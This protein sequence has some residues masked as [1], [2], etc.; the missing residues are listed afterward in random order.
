MG[1]A[2]RAAAGEPAAELPSHEVRWVLER[3]FEGVAGFDS[4]GIC[5][6]T[7][8]ALR[9]M[10]GFEE[11]IDFRLPWHQLVHP[12]DAERV[13]EARDRLAGFGSFEC[14]LRCFRTDGAP[15]VGRF[16]VFEV[17]PQ[18]G[19]RTAYISCVE[20]VTEWK[21]IEAALNLRTAEQ[22]RSNAELE[23]FAHIAAHDLKEP[24][25]KLLAFS[26]LLEK[27]L[28]GDLP[29]AAAKDLGF[30]T[31]A[32]RRLQDLVQDLLALSRAGRSEVRRDSLALDD[33]VDEALSD[34][35]LALEQRSVRIERTRL[36]QVVGDRTLLTQLYHNL[37]G[38]ALKFCEES[39]VISLTC[40]TT[41][42]DVVLGVRDN[43]IGVDPAYAE[44]IFQ[45]F[46]R[47]HRRD[48]YEGTGIG[49]AICKT[50]VERHGGTIWVESEPGKGAHFRFRLS[51]CASGEDA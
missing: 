3:L 37:I 44:Q 48:A 2:E 21:E 34:L 15:L 31:D 23:Q 19:S 36:P 35:A 12:D 50:A 47:L 18:E 10:F 42:E 29:E 26:S 22:E 5:I 11:G 32:A 9:R 1:S 49:L 43:G 41:G 27:D 16:R 28:G 45:P 6:W 30:I 14:E 20:D 38:N 24:A 17:P 46:R 25:R 40:E 13:R 51:G 8:H 4:E 33:C 39:P 7:N